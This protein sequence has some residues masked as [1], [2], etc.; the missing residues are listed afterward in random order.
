MVWMMATVAMLNIFSLNIMKKN[1]DSNE[2][3]C[4]QQLYNIFEQ[5]RTIC[6][7]LLGGIQ[8]TLK[9]KLFPYYIWILHSKLY[10]LY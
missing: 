5:K 9:V 8:H 6:K 7:I 3:K 2:I 10:A 4:F 1:Y